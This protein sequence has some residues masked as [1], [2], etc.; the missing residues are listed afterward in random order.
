MSLIKNMGPCCCDCETFE[1][2]LF[3]LYQGDGKN[4]RIDPITSGTVILYRYSQGTDPQHDVTLNADISSLSAVTPYDAFYLDFTLDLYEN[5]DKVGTITY[6]DTGGTET[7]GTADVKVIYKGCEYHAPQCDV[8]AAMV[9]GLPMDG[10][11][12]QPEP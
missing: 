8:R 9:T 1:R 12:E 7:Y 11:I 5:G 3:R 10:L 6:T 2:L 4:G